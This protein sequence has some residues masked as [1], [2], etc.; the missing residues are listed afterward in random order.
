MLNKEVDKVTAEWTE[1]RVVEEAHKEGHRTMNPCPLKLKLQQKAIQ[2]TGCYTPWILYHGPS[3][4]SDLAYLDDG[5]T[6]MGK[7][8]D[9]TDVQNTVIG[10]L[11]KEGFLLFGVCGYLAYHE[12]GKTSAAVLAIARKPDLCEGICRAI[13]TQTEML[14]EQNCKLDVILQACR[15]AAVPGLRGEMR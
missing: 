3:G 14:R 8:A 7:T 5:D 1:Q 10:T 13:N 6:I 12:I 2:P 4:Y 9:L 15:L 11:H